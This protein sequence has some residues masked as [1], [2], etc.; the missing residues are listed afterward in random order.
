[1][2]IQDRGEAISEAEVGMQVAISLD[3][4]VVGRHIY[5]NDV[6]YVKVPEADAKA[7]LEKFRDRL[8]AEEIDALKK[9]VEIMRRESP[10][11]A[12]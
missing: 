3:K 4:P 9:F 1:M 2:Q 12:A 6:L 7:L 10:F 5:E 8:S 11:W